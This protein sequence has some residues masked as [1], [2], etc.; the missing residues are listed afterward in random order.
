MASLQSLYLPKADKRAKMAEHTRKDSDEAKELERIERSI[1]SK[2]RSTI[3]LQDLMALLMVVAR[4]RAHIRY[5]KAR[6]RFVFIAHAPTSS[7]TSPMLGWSTGDIHS[8][9][10]D[11]D[12][13]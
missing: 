11:G 1:I 7:G 8:G 2:L 6:G 10:Q 5:S 9:S 12:G 4:D 13:R 3:Q